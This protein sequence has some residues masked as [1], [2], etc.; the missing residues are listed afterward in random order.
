[1][2]APHDDVIQSACELHSRFFEPC[3]PLL[4]EVP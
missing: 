3:P 2:I 4:K 1:L